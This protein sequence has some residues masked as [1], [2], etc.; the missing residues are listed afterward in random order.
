MATLQLA[1]A[2]QPTSTGA[3]RKAVISSGVTAPL[4]LSITRPHHTHSDMAPNWVETPRP[5]Y[6]PSLNKLA[7]QRRKV[8]IEAVLWHGGEVSIYPDVRDLR[9][10]ASGVYG[11]VFAWQTLTNGHRW[12]IKDLSVE[13]THE[14]PGDNE[15]VGGVATFTLEEVAPNKNLATLFEGQGAPQIA[16]AA[17]VALQ[18]P[19]S[20]PRRHTVGAGQTL[21]DI[22]LVVYGDGNQ[23][24]RIADTNGIIDPRRLTV[25]RVLI[26][27]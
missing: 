3:S 25:G 18:A 15:P 16:A 27:P 21:F 22:A 20:G 1:V 11:V 19:R 5:G 6:L 13:V 10:H 26:L 2:G 12:I 8:S 24:R 4:V 7:P 9:L 14:R 17:P 23:W